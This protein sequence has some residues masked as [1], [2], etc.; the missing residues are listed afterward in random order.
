MTLSGAQ[1]SLASDL[2]RY[3]ETCHEAK[4]TRSPAQP[5]VYRAF[6]DQLSRECVMADAV[7]DSA[8][9]RFTYTR[10]DTRLD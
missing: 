1:P 3:Q 8:G 4:R 10:V 6:T 2:N 7:E 5:I 9:W